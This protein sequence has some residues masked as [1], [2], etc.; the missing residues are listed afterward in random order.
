M[1]P[2]LFLHKGGHGPN[3]LVYVDDILMVGKGEDLPPLKR[4]LARIFT[5]TDLG[6]ASFFL[7]IGQE[8]DR[9]AGTFTLSQKR[10]GVDVLER[11]GMTECRSTRTPLPSGFKFH[12]PQGDR[13]EVPQRDYQ[14]AKGSLMYLVTGTRPDL[15]F[16]VGAAS[17]FLMKEFVSVRLRASA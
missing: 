17:R 3:L 12:Q 1:E 11:F 6:E 8:M 5:V 9:K 15:A 7:G 4:Q 13:V 16:A 14:S 2:S 10:Y